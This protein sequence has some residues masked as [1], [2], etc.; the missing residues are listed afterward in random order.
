[1]LI[2]NQ[3]L[4]SLPAPDGEH[5]LD[6]QPGDISVDESG[7]CHNLMPHLILGDDF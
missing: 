3:K 5:S 7:F 1:M 4:V 2:V 6:V